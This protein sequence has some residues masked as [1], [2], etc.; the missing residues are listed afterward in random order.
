MRD[1]PS[2]PYEESCEVKHLLH[3]N[4]QIEYAFFF[5]DCLVKKVSF[6]DDIDQ[7]FI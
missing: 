6:C 7:G 5:K 1:F 2:C 3:I 4:I